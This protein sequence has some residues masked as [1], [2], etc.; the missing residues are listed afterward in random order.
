MGN[1][2]FIITNYLY[3]DVNDQNWQII[4]TYIKRATGID[5]STSEIDI[6]NVYDTI[7]NILEMK[8]TDDICDNPIFKTVNDF[9]VCNDNAIILSLNLIIYSLLKLYK[10]L[11]YEND[12][13]S[14]EKKL[15]KRKIMA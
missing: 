11:Q 3:A 13:N 6:G 15:K 1:I 9:F 12:S 14:G 4:K 2:N 5:L 7:K 8:N 10:T